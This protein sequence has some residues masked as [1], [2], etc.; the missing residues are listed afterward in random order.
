MLL[1]LLDKLLSLLSPPD[2]DEYTARKQAGE[3]IMQELTE[4][5]HQ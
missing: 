1:E 4:G 5:A 3:R 2:D